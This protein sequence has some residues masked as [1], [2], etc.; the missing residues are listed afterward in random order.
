MEILFMLGSDIKAK[1][2]EEAK[3]SRKSVSTNTTRLRANIL[4]GDIDTLMKKIFN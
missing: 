1:N 4:Y 3:R 2:L